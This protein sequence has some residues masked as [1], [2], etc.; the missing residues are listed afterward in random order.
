M[1]LHYDHRAHAFFGARYR[2]SERTFLQRL[3]QCLR[4]GWER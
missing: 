3:V 4:Q 2:V 1:T